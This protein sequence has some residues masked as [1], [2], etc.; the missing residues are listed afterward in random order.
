VALL[1]ALLFLVLTAV[2]V[3]PISLVVAG[4]RLSI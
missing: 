4:V 1:F 2:V 3:I